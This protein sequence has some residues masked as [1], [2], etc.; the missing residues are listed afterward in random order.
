MG[1]GLDLEA[2]AKEQEISIGGLA[3]PT[4]PPAPIMTVDALVAYGFREWPIGQH[5]KHDRHWQYCLRTELGKK[6]YVQ[7]R[8]WAFSRYSSPERGRVHD[9]FDA[10][11]QFDMNGPKTFNISCS[12]NDMTP[13]QVV[14]WFEGVH[15]RMGCTYYEKYADELYNEQ[16][17]KTHY[18][19]EE[20]GRYLPPE[21]AVAPFLCPGCKYEAESG[22]KPG[23]LKRR[24]KRNL[25]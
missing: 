24:K 2:Q 10:E 22:F 5:D 11:A 17:E 13:A 3:E 21:E 18:N 14:D 12:V 23:V 19:C 25:R 7:V 16:G 6:L 1:I 15:T 4:G 20:C 9:S 8:L